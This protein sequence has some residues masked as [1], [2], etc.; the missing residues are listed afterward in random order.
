[1]R[2]TLRTL[3][4]W[5]DGMLPAASSA[6]LQDRVASSTAARRIVE[7]IDS[8]LSDQR[9]QAPDP[10]EQGFGG[11]A[12]V[13]AEY[14]D[15]VLEPG[16]LDEFERL[17]LESNERLAEVAGCHRLLAEV[18]RSPG[19]LPRIDDVDQRRILG[20]ALARTTPH[21]A[22][23][24]PTDPRPSPGAA[25]AGPSSMS[26]AEERSVE[27]ADTWPEVLANAASTTVPTARDRRRPER[28]SAA[29]W[30]LAIAATVLLGVLAGVLAWSVGRSTRGNRSVGR[31]VPPPAV[32]VA[33]EPS[34]PEP[35]QREPVPAVSPETTHDTQEPGV[36]DIAIDPAGPPSE[37][38]ERPV[39][40]VAVLAGPVDPPIDP[41]DDAVDDAPGAVDPPAATVPFGSALAIAVPPARPATPADPD[42]STAPEAAPA[43]V[44]VIQ[45]L[46]AV[47]TVGGRQPILAW[48]G[49]GTP[50]G[51]LVDRENLTVAGVDDPLPL[52]ATLLAPAAGQAMVAFDG[53]NIAISG[54]GLV[55]LQRDADD[56]PMVDVLFGTV[57]VTSQRDPSPPLTVT[58]AGITGHLGGERGSA[59][60]IDVALRRPPGPPPVDATPAPWSVR[61]TTGAVAFSWTS[62]PSGVDAQADAAAAWAAVGGVGLDDDG[63]IPPQTTRR[64]SSGS[65][66]VMDNGP[67]A[68]VPGHRPDLA[69]LPASRMQERLDRSAAESLAHGLASGDLAVEV[70][71]RLAADPRCECAAAASATLAAM[72]DYDDAVRLLCE[73]SPRGVLY[74]GQWRRLEAAVVPLALAR[75]PE[76]AA[77]LADAFSRIGP[78]GAAGDLMALAAGFEADQL[79]AGAAEALVAALDD[80]RLVVRRYALAN[81]LALLPVSEADAGRYR[82]EAPPERRRDAITWWRDRVAGQPSRRRSS[83]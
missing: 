46:A 30:L 57:V 60:A 61:M 24:A 71:R 38:V 51:V 66:A 9:I 64:W 5:I 31:P 22:G 33:P 26:V 41:P 56:R 42:I 10:L 19:G 20:T 21:G 59:L 47:A 49:N 50:D 13:T 73:D 75:G 17:S 35:R 44:A 48:P 2:L 79:A 67:G 8:L 83:P 53:W 28:S 76:H 80:P 27:T 12:N 4:A 37:P 65:V 54:G 40:E 81:L 78:P 3:L 63:V 62:R 36:A 18:I 70:L 69:R 43:E 16:R 72:G 58:A 39:E 34:P 45:P 77:L 11:D 29:A 7:R 55:V 1:M 23:G 25:A 6:E 15:N 14:L 52:P 82:A 68:A 74:D 32:T